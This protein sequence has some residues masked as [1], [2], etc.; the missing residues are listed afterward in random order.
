MFRAAAHACCRL[1]LQ[2]GLSTSECLP[3]CTQQLCTTAEDLAADRIMLAHLTLGA[4][5]FQRTA[6]ELSLKQSDQER[7]AVQTGRKKYS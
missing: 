5:V 3:V 7:S 1:Y 4:R 6:K 2:L